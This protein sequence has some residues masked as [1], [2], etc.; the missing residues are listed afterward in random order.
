MSRHLPNS[1]P[2]RGLAW[3][4]IAAAAAALPVAAEA[5]RAG[6]KGSQAA[7]GVHPTTSATPQSS[8]MPSTAQHGDTSALDSSGDYRQEVQACREGRTGEDRATCLRE[9]RNAQAERRRGRLDTAGDLQA[10]AL[11][12]CNVHRVQA[13]RD[14]CHERVLSAASV[15][16]SVASG[17]LLREYAVTVPAEPEAA[18]GAGPQA[19]P[20]LNDEAPY[21]EPES[22]PETD[23][24]TPLQETP[25][26]PYAP[27]E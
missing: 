16:G 21:E 2:R 14:A 22:L 26:A 7:Q 11:A 24:D 6:A 20:R 1:P 4:A 25:E 13:D 19:P 17:G 3:L 27:Q 15:S 12:R 5:H 9:A 18:M 23:P 10:N 8:P